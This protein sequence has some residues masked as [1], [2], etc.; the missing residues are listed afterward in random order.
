MPKLPW[1]I[2]RFRTVSWYISWSPWRC[3]KRIKITA[4]TIG[5]IL[6]C[7]SILGSSTSDHW[8]I[9]ACTGWERRTNLWKVRAWGGYDPSLFF[10]LPKSSDTSPEE[11]GTWLHVSLSPSYRWLILKWQVCTKFGSSNLRKIKW[12]GFLW[13]FDRCWWVTCRFL[14]PE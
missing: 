6:C 7:K 2:I 12:K 8:P 13:S 3:V 14:Y 5:F 1:R 4:G 10:L 9:V 11:V